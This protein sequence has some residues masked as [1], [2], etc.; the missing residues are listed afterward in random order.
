MDQIVTASIV[1]YNTPHSLL[2]KVIKSI[3]EA[4]VCK[5]LYVIDNFNEASVFDFS[6][7]DFIEYINPSSNLGYGAGHNV[8]LRK[9]ISS[10]SFHFVINPDISFE[11]DVLERMIERMNLDES[12]GQLMPKVVY[13]NGEIQYLCKLLPSPMDLLFRRFLVGPLKYIAVKNN[14]KYELRFTGYVNEMNV[15][16]LS[17]CFMLFRV[18]ALNQ[19]G[20]FDERFF[21]YP[22]DIDITRR[23]HARFKTIFFPEVSV[24]HH[25]AKASYKNRKMLFVHIVNMIRYFNKWGWFFDEERKKVNTHTL[26]LLRVNQNAD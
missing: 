26:E 6:R 7:F 15:P 9:V 22:E 20:L 16:Y 17:G 14:Y 25:H 5:R 23:M 4:G 21:M 19:V 3:A 2:D 13:P 12:I 18:S 10:S 24:I 8:A 1:I 11:G